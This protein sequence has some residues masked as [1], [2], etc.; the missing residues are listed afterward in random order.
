MV[1]CGRPGSDG[2]L[3]AR[4]LS[5]QQGIVCRYGS[6]KKYP[7][8]L[9]QCGIRLALESGRPISQVAADLV[10]HPETLRKKIRQ[11]EAE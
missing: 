11:H 6:P 7:E 3:K 10:M 9:V 5:C 2:D 8:E 4:V 1:D